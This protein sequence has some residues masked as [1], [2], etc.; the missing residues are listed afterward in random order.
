MPAACAITVLTQKPL[1]WSAEA[2]A[3]KTGTELI[4]VYAENMDRDPGPSHESWLSNPTKQDPFITRFLNLEVLQYC[5]SWTAH[6][7]QDTRVSFRRVCDRH[8]R[9]RALLHNQ[10]ALVDQLLG[11]Y[12]CQTTTSK[13]LCLLKEIETV[14]QG[15]Q[16]Q[17][18]MVQPGETSQV[19]SMLILRMVIFAALLDLCADTGFLLN[20]EF[21][22]SIVKML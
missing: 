11:Y 17:P 2:L 16:C 3:D 22:D 1:L 13:S 21:K 6:L 15:L 12:P 5:L 9:V 18:V 4:K 10:L 20:G 8:S 19:A 14:S 7:A